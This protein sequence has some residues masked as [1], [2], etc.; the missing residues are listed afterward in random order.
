LIP[1]FLLS[2]SRFVPP[3]LPEGKNI[4]VPFLYLQKYSRLV[5]VGRC[6]ASGTEV[7]T[8]LILFPFTL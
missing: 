2:F 5:S 8:L 6:A 3:F 1:F 4:L 7:S